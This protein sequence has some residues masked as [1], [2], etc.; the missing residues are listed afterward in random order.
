[1]ALRK[2]YTTPSGAVAHYFRVT[3]YRVDHDAREASAVLSAYVQPDEASPLPPFALVPVFAKVRVSG[4]DF[5]ELL[6]KRALAESI[7]DIVAHFYYAAKAGLVVG[8]CGAGF[9]ADAGDV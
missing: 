4:Q 1:M 7:D 6:S 9:F 2:P 8:D 3:S 5:D